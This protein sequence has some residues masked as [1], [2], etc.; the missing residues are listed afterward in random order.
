MTVVAIVVAPFFAAI[1][2]A[3]WS[4]GRCGRSSAEP[5]GTWSTWSELSRAARDVVGAWRSRLAWLASRL[6]V[7]DVARL[8]LGVARLWLGVA[9]MWLD[10]VRLV[11][12]LV[13]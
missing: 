3:T 11:A 12:R 8:W 7:V 1:I 10:A 2:I 9:C 4:G 13:A 6:G 5:L